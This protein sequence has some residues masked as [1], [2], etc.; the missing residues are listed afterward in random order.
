M[1]RIKAVLFEETPLTRSGDESNRITPNCK[2]N[3]GC[4]A[5]PTV[6][7]VAGRFDDGFDKLT[8]RV[9]NRSVVILFFK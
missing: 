4:A 7:R 3:S 1:E 2:N 8:R 9:C 5:G 6:L